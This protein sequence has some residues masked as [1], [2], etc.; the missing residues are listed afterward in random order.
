MAGNTFGK[1]FCVTTF[2][3]SHGKMIGVVIDGCP[4]GILLD[5]DWIQTQMDRRRPGQSKITTQRKEADKVEFVS[6]IY[7]G[8]TTGTPL[9]AIILNGDQREKDYDHL[10][11]AYR[12]SHADFTYDQKYGIRD[13][14]GGGRSSA[15]ETAARVV[16]GSVAQLILRQKGIRI[17]AFVSQVGSIRLETPYFDLDLSKTD[18]NL[19]RCPDLHVAKKMEDLIS[20]TQKKGDTVGGVITAVI[21]GCPAGLGE[22]VFDKLHADLGKAMLSINA[23]KGFEYGSGFDSTSLHGSEHNDLFETK[24]G[25]IQTKTNRSGGIQGGISNGM[26]IYFRV[27]FKPVATLMREQMSVDK[28]GRSTS[29]EG[30]G[31]HD[32]CVVPRAVPIV[33]AMAALTIIDHLMRQQAVSPSDVPKKIRRRK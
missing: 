10:K 27:A 3:E 12:P 4:A 7:E 15:R 16:A 6:G 17:E 21:T 8:K 19:V 30:K 9:A 26:D 2:G 18:S 32:P 14:R 33:E 31:R 5:L 23:V 29:I 22:P 25:K 28:S 1:L 13:P 11:S 24:N 20:R